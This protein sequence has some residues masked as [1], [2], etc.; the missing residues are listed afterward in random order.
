M[1]AQLHKVMFEAR[2]LYVPIYA[3]LVCDPANTAVHV[4]MHAT[5]MCMPT[6]DDANPSL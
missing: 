5:V 2:V 3:I 6:A 1:C 4:V